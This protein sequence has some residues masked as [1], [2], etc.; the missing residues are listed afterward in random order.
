MGKIEVIEAGYFKLDGGAMFGVVPRSI[1]EKLNKPDE[2]NLCTWSMRLLYL[3]IG[4]KKILIDTGMGSKQSEK[5]FSY[6]EPHG[7]TLHE[8]LSEKGIQADSITDVI[9]THLHFDHGGGAIQ[10]EN[11]KSVTTFP[12]ARY[13]CSHS[14]WEW[15][16]N[17]N[18]REKASFLKDNL[19]P[20]EESGQLNF[21]ENPGYWIPEI[22][23]KFY[24]GHTEGMMIPFIHWDKHILVYCADLLPSL[25]HIPLPYIMAYDTRPLLSLEEKKFFLEEAA[26]NRYIL[27]FEHD[28]IHEC[29]LVETSEKGI[30]SRETLSLVSAMGL[31]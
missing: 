15:A 9:L 17:P 13:W 3:E 16:I 23:F 27:F 19:I 2:R 8:S 5:F 30:R 14:Q 20:L 10:I 6:Y 11:G 12:N 1:W 24:H 7:K 25:G 28:P 29:A 26:V 4:E 18:D 21:I 22:E 31:I